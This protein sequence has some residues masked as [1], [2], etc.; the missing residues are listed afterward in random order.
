MKK[1]EIL[2][3]VC[4]IAL[5][6]CNKEKNNP[7]LSNSDTALVNGSSL[8]SG[9]TSFPGYSFCLGVPWLMQ[10]PPGTWTANYNCGPTCVVMLSG[11]FNC[12]PVNSAQITAEKTWLY[13]YTGNSAYNTP[14]GTGTGLPLLKILLSQK[15]GLSSRILTGV[16]VDDILNEAFTGQP[17]IAGVQIAG[18]NLVTSGGAPH[19]VIVVGYDGCNIIINDPGT[20]YGFNR[21]YSKATFSAS[22][23]SQGKP[24]MPVTK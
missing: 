10:I 21:K 20:Q 13:N 15:H 7:D 17:C 8:K 16:N 4:L 14:N 5:F 22:W 18:G 23:T 9:G 12:T 19:W 6:S 3:F 2:L 1:V 24:Y 11:Y